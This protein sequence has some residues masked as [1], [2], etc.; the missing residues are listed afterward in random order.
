VTPGETKARCRHVEKDVPGYICVPMSAQGNV[1]GVFTCALSPQDAENTDVAH[2]AGMAA[3]RCALALANVRLRQQ[4]RDIS[5]QDSLTGLYNRRFADE[6][7]VRE[8]SRADREGTTLCV[9]MLDLDHFKQV[10]DIHG[11]EVGDQVLQKVGRLLQASFRESDVCCRFG[12][13]EFLVILPNSDAKGAIKHAEILRK[14]VKRI[15]FIHKGMV[16]GNM[17]VSIGLATYPDPISDPDSLVA[18]A[19]TALY[20]A[21]RAGRDRVC[22]ASVAPP[23]AA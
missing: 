17:A 16:V 5:I 22:I 2:T 23:H 18:A 13:E 19:D 7:L 11:H 4:L 15:N 8:L 6:V 10:N 21:K 20:E 14:K 9:V 12:G 1:L 3:E